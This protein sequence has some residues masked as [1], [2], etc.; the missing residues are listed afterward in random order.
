MLQ[1]ISTLRSFLNGEMRYRIGLRTDQHVVEQI[2]A[3][4]P[5]AVTAGDN[6]I[7]KPATDRD[8]A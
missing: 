7:E 5:G 4:R 8:D 6:T 2:M 3:A 1:S